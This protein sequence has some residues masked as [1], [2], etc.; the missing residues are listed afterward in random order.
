MTSDEK[1]KLKDLVHEQIASE[2]ELFRRVT[3]PDEIDHNSYVILNDVLSYASKFHR[4]ERV[5]LWC[6]GGGGS[7]S[8][9]RAMMDIIRKHGK[10]DGILCGVAASCHGMIWAA[11]DVRYAT[12]LAALGVHEASLDFGSDTLTTSEL[13]Q[14]LAMLHD[15]DEVA[16]HVYANASGLSVEWWREQSHAGIAVNLMSA[17][18][19]V[20]MGMAAW[21]E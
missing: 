17:P 16:L 7:T 6:N 18:R 2:Y 19:L 4:Y 20:A 12:P 9:A 5:Q 15:A 14:R 10:V 3:L 21:Y 1:P 11:C 8:D 13:R